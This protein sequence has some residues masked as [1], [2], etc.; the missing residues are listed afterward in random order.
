MYY[1][2][3][4]NDSSDLDNCNSFAMCKKK[5]TV[6]TSYIIFLLWSSPAFLNVYFFLFFDLLMLVGNNMQDLAEQ[7]CYK[8]RT[9]RTKLKTSF[10]C[11][12]YLIPI[13]LYFGIIIDVFNVASMLLFM[14]CFLKRRCEI[15]VFIIID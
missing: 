13:S 9:V 12:V 4:S 3:L 1:F 5:I 2:P 11:L 15:Q 10:H 14:F 7:I 8:T 6:E